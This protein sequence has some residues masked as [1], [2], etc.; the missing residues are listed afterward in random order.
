M[1]LKDTEIA[2]YV[3]DKLMTYVES[4]QVRRMRTLELIT[5]E[6]WGFKL[7]DLSPKYQDLFRKIKSNFISGVA[8]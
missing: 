2:Q 8:P 7:E 5:Q 1:T 4:P 6:G 3:I